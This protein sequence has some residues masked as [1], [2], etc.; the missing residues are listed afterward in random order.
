MDDR[1]LATATMMAVVV[2]ALAGCPPG[3]T[4]VTQPSGGATTTG[5][6]SSSLPDQANPAPGSG[7]GICT[8]GSNIDITRTIT[9]TATS[10]LGDLG[11]TMELAAGVQDVGVTVPDG[12]YTWSNRPLNG[13]CNPTGPTAGPFTA[14]FAFTYRAWVDESNQPDVCVFRSRAD[15]GSF[16][17]TGAAPLDALILAS[18]KDQAERGIDRA[19]ADRLNRLVHANRGFPAGSEPRC[20]D[21]AVLPP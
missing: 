4:P 14:S 13:G 7:N 16:T 11:P 9:G 8:P 3:S 1:G 17:V 20:P 12:V 21:W 10:T 18:V 5:P 2:A 15:F 6:F 19:V